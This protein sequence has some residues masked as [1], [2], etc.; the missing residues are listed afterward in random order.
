MKCKVITNS[1]VE[2]VVI[3]TKEYNNTIKE[4]E[5]YILNKDIELLGFIDKRVTKLNLSDIYCFIVED[6]KVYGIT[7]NE[8]YLIKQRIYVLE[9][10]Y[11]NMFIKINQSCLI[12]IDKI[13]RFDASLS[14]FLL[15]TLKNGYSDY[16]S[17][18]NLKNV[19]ERL[20]L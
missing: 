20:G 4:I 10:M 2:E 13:K 17:R 12:N 18:R 7:K 16:V 14:G 8:K 3:Y 9:E 6:N 11:N 5:E 15:V 1:D 19:K